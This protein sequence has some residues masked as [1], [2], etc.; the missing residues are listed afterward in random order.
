MKTYM[1]T[2]IEEVTYAV[3]EEGD[4][5]A[6]AKAERIY[7]ELYGKHSGSVVHSQIEKV[8]D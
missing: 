5:Q 3:E 4:F 7:L 2:V 6:R 8:S 1:V